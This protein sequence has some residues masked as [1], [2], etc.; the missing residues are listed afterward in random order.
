MFKSAATF[1]DLHIYLIQFLLTLYVCLTNVLSIILLLDAL[2]FNKK[3]VQNIQFCYLC[4]QTNLGRLF[5]SEL[6]EFR[7]QNN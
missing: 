7:N 3:Y 4:T 6:I 5:Y 2:N 1:S